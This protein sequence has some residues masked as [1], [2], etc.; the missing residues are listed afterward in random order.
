[1]IRDAVLTQG[2]LSEAVAEAD[3]LV[4]EVVNPA[5]AQLESLRRSQAK[6]KAEFKRTLTSL[7]AAGLGAQEGLAAGILRDLEERASGLALAISEQEALVSG[8]EARRV[9]LDV[10]QRALATFESIYDELRPA[11][12]QELLR[13]LVKR[14]RVGPSEIEVEVF[15]GGPVLTRV[16]GLRR[17]P[18]PDARGPLAQK[19]RARSMR[20]NPSNSVPGAFWLPGGD[21]RQNLGRRLRRAAEPAV[22]T[23]RGGHYRS[24]AERVDAIGVPLEFDPVEAVA[25]W[26]TRDG[27][28]VTAAPAIG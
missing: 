15:E 10:I 20:V 13:L 6:V 11:E 28:D 26:S 16:D 2:L 7:A 27:E 9:D 8:W 4:N 21:R 22:S 25:D 18:H 17:S 1:M 14:V 23:G 24:L 3:R 12:R 19:Q 5:R